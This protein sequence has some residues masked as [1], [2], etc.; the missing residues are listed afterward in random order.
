MPK[1]GSCSI[2]GVMPACCEPCRASSDRSTYSAMSTV[3]CLDC[4]RSCINLGLFDPHK[5]RVPLYDLQHQ[6]AILNVSIFAFEYKKHVRCSDVGPRNSVVGLHSSC[7]RVLSHSDTHISRHVCN[8]VGMRQ[9]QPR[10]QGS[11]S[12]RAMDD[13]EQMAAGC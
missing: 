3:S 12:E 7:M 10:D 6:P 13:C 4:V 8:V 1:I 5:C 9:L 11:L 2:C